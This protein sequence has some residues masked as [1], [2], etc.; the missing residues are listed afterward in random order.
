MYSSIESCIKINES[1]IT[2]M[3]S[4][5]R[6]IR[7]GDGLSPV[8]FCL[9]MNDLP[10]GQQLSKCNIRKSPSQLPNV[11]RRSFTNKSLSRGI[12]TVP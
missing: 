7:Q 10:Q 5:N 6:G 4:C 11:C 9:F 12:T 1:E 2:E 8:L 3:F